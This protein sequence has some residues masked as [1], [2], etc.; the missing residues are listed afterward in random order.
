MDSQ[1]LFRD[2]VIAIKEKKDLA[3]GRKLLTQALRLD[4]NNEMAWVWLSRTVTDQEKKLQCLDRALSINPDNDQAMALR[5]KL[6]GRDG[7]LAPVDEP[8]RKSA[9]K[10]PHQP[11]PDEEKRIKTMLNK[12]EALLSEEKTEEAIEQ[13]V[14]VLEIQPDHEIALNNAVRYLSRLKYV[15][16]AKELVSQAIESGATRVSVYLTAIDIAKHQGDQVEADRLRDKLARLPSTDDATVSKIVDHY[17][18]NGMESKAIELLEHAL[19][20]HGNS[21]KL[22]IRMGDLEKAMSNEVESRRYYE[23]AARLGTRTK[24]GKAA[25]TKLME[26]APLLTDKERGSFVLALREALGFGVA[27]LLMGWQDAGLNFAIMGPS[28][29]IGVVISIVGGYLLITATS[30]PQQQPLAKILGGQVPEKKKKEKPKLDYVEPDKTP[31][32]GVVHDDTELPI[33]PTGL[34]VFIGVVG[35]AILIF[36]F[37]MV[38][39]QA[40]QLLGDPVPPTDI[41]SI[42]ELLEEA[43]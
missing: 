4:P 26:S 38:F 29:W 6:L 43:Q 5:E 25:D 27:F 10:T 15:D 23:R 22:L 41:P 20:T 16:D 2:G 21:Q 11:T 28:R 12:A 37:M 13:W 42:Q 33:I 8:A 3:E 35:L 36:A 30:S 17:M 1:T 34:R 40:V 9:Q 39:S 18:E 19:E 32:M 7:E 24:E 14:R 31:Q